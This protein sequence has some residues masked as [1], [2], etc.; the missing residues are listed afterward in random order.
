[1]CKR[2]QC[3]YTIDE[4]GVKNKPMDISEQLNNLLEQYDFSARELA[5]A[6]GLSVSVISRYRSGTRH[7]S[8]AQLKRLADGF[9]QLMKSRGREID[10]A[11]LFDIPAESQVDTSML[12][13]KFNILVSILGI[14][15]NDFSRFCSYDPSMI[16]RVR[17][18]Q[19]ELT[20][21]E[22]FAEDVGRFLYQKYRG[23]DSD[24]IIAAYMGASKMPE[25]IE[26]YTGVVREWL[27]SGELYAKEMLIPFAD[28][29]GDPDIEAI[30]KDD[31]FDFP[32]GKALLRKG[33][34]RVCH[35][36]D[37][38]MSG[39]LDFLRYAIDSGAKSLYMY[40]DFSHHRTVL[41]GEYSKEW[42]NLLYCAVSR[43]IDIH[44][45]TNTES[46]PEKLS[47]SMERMLPVLIT[48]RLRLYSMSVPKS[49][50]F[51]NHCYVSD[52]IVM[53]GEGLQGLPEQA[54]CILSFEKED[55]L[56]YRSQMKHLLGKARPMMNVYTK[57]DEAFFRH[58]LSA[59]AN[60]P[61]ERVLVIH[62]L[63]VGTMD[64]ALAEGIISRS[65]LT[66]EER[67]RF[68]ELYE[69]SRHNLLNILRNEESVFDNVYIMDEDELTAE[70]PKLVSINGFLPFDI[71]CSPEE[72]AELRSQA[73]ALSEKY[74]NYSF[75]RRSTKL[76][77]GMNIVINKGKWIII[78]R[79]KEPLMHFVIRYPELR[80]LIENIVL[81]LT[82]SDP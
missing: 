37:E 10:A 47:M 69:E 82:E 6:A 2:K 74:P 13:R 55:I 73:F 30:L 41:E 57:E 49:G 43:G 33:E 48:G 54:R 75:V 39:E 21:P 35:G 29:L 40:S 56:Y 81:L 61:G 66:D 5:D 77:S 67:I 51:F 4:K 64:R 28:K 44:L 63:H 12:V 15:M 11:R 24:R 16:S 53:Y 31:G 32:D 79:T 7:P 62:G 71:R 59:D 80:S 60:N 17:S 25:D 26:E 58:F 52:D 3:N 72:Y 46:S 68:M 42:V 19:R 36:L 76:V 65:A 50:V 9:A 27:C 8:P 14:N 45:I 1:M 22:G 78:S 38:I 23:H 34:G 70:R 18:K 20:D